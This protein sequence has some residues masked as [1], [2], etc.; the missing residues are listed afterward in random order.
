M[1]QPV[2]QDEIDLMRFVLAQPDGVITD[3]DGPWPY[4]RLVYLLAKWSKRGWWSASNEIYGAISRVSHGDRMDG[5]PAM[6]AWLD[7]QARRGDAG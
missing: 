4:R 7:T 5:R 2:R 1:S 3:F 6:Q